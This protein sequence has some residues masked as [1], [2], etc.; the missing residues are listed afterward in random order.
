MKS[1][2]LPVLQARGQNLPEAW[3]KSLIMLWE[4]GIE[5]ETKYD[6][7]GDPHLPNRFSKKS[8]KS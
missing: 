4:Q 3:E 6:R 5:V 2:N 8:G 7:K 1:G